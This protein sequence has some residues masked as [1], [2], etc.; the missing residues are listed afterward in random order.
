M[1]HL[2]LLCALLA[3]TPALAAPP[4]SATQQDP[5][6]ERVVLVARHGV[7]SPTKPPQTLQTQTGHV[8]AQWP[9]APGELTDHGKQAL[10]Q[11]VGMVRQ[12]YV[13]AGLLPAT[14]CPTPGSV[15]IWADSKDHR[16]RES[17]AIWAEHL[18]ASCKQQSLSLEASQEDPIFAGPATP[19]NVQEQNAITREF[20][21]RASAIPPT[22]GNSMNTLQAVLAPTACTT[23]KPHCLSTNTAIL[24]WKNDKPHLEGGIATGGTAAENLLLEYAQ[25]MLVHAEPFGQQNPATLIEQV[26]PLHTEESWLIRRLPTLAAHKGAT[27]ISVVQDVL[28]GKPSTALPA[29]TEQTRLLV[30]SGHDTN[31]DMLATFYGLD[32]SFTDQ[33]DP[34]APDTTLA[35]ELWRSPNGSY[36]TVRLFHQSLEA[37]RTLAAPDPAVDMQVIASGPSLQT[38]HPTTMH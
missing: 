38:L 9:V 3:S 33:P 2:T 31:L 22:V 4:A 25:G 7:R 13:K 15:T 12:H 16:T 10:E 14:G 36:V 23:D 34:T 11:M 20:N 27:M 18:A 30:L 32:W 1:R 6:L 29:A 26:F 5:V 35:F 8:W 17:G 28:A 37:L 21:Q 24:A 19:L